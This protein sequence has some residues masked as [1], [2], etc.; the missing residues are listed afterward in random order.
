MRAGKLN[1]GMGLASVRHHFRWYEAEWL[2]K[3]SR[4]TVTA[5][6][7]AQMHKDHE[8]K[9][10]EGKTITTSESAKENGELAPAAEY[11]PDQNLLYG[12]QRL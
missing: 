12:L 7:N 9:S 8:R 6:T 2:W 5:L 3:Q 11:I 1:P 10:L 4:H